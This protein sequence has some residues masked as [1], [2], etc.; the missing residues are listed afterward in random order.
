MAASVIIGWSTIFSIG[1]KGAPAFKKPVKYNLP[2]LSSNIQ[3]TDVSSPDA[4]ECAVENEERPG[5]LVPG[6]EYV[7]DAVD[8]AKL[9]AYECR[10]MEDLTEKACVLWTVM[11]RVEKNG[12]TIH[13]VLRL[14]SQYA[15]YEESEYSEEDF[16]LALDVIARWEKEQ[17]GQT[18]VG[19]VLPKEYMWFFGDGQHNWFCDQFSGDYNLWDYSLDT[20]YQEC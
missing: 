6:S 14:A 19:R 16:C 2:I 15:F 7:K 12:D 11:N 18:D 3:I 9:L 5:F 17:S 20:P 13:N 10:G 1:I 8:M 4:A